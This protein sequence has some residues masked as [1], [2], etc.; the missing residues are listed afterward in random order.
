MEGTDVLLNI[1]DH[2]PDGI[3]VMTPAGRIVYRNR[4][5]S[6]LFPGAETSWE[7]WPWLC[8]HL[9][10]T[11]ENPALIV[12]PTREE[13]T[14]YHVYSSRAKKGGHFL[15]F[16][17][18]PPITDERPLHLAETG[19]PDEG[20]GP[21]F[22]ELIGKDPH[23]LRALTIAYRAATSDLPV[24]IMG[25]SGT[26]KEIVARAIHETS[27]RREKR[28][29][30]VNCAAIPDSLIESEL[31]G[32]E[33]GAFTGARKE[34]RGGYFDLAHEG[35][36]FLDEIGDAS[37]QTQSKLLRVLEDG[38]FK[39][40]GGNRNVVVD[41]RII[42]ATNQDLRKRIAEK[43]F[44]EDLYYRLNTFTIELP[45]L[46]ERKGD[47]PLLVEYFLAG[48]EGEQKRMKF[49]PSTMEIL[50]A[51]DWPGNVRELRG[52]VNYAINMSSSRL[53]SPT[54]LPRFL[55]ASPQFPE[56]QAGQTDYA[57]DDSLP[58]ILREVER[59]LIKESL[60]QTPNR[61]Q[62][63]RRLGISRRTFYAKLKAYGLD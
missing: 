19:A 58:H 38:C 8:G 12:F 15:V 42:S 10:K 57:I 39:R 29:V 43:T 49:L 22:R 45:P 21:A 36:I 3:A 7:K 6:R 26:G 44:R 61:S 52:V 14:I 4:A 11:T 1:L 35:T 18:I 23:F 25:E 2:S 27:R 30:D 13:I 17:R 40:V 16:V 37:L 63:I 47:I 46:R 32:Y 59:T 56:A 24:L 53:V 51:Y 33:R 54:A 34:G 31:F 5:F 28:L 62:A 9:A 20:L 50:L 41:V 48:A 55:F 60:E